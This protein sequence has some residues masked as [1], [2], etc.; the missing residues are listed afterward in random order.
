MKRRDFITISSL[1]SAGFTL[2]HCNNPVNS[3]NDTDTP[4]G[5]VSESAKNI[6]VKGKYDV[7]VC[8]GGPAG[9]AAAIKSGRAGV[10]TLLVETGGCLGGTWTAGLLPVILDYKNKTGLLQEI[11]TALENMNAR[12]IKHPT[13]A[14]NFD[15]ESMKLLLEKMCLDVGVDIL[16]HTRAVQVIKDKD[17]NISHVLTESKSFREAWES[18]IIVDATGDGD[19]GALAGCE[20]DMGKGEENSIQPMSFL[21]LISG[22]VHSE[23]GDYVRKMKNSWENNQRLKKL[24][25]AGGVETSYRNPMIFPIRENLFSIMANHEYGFH[26]TNAKD[27][28]EATINARQELHSIINALKS[29]GGIWKDIMIVATPSHIGVREGRRI[30]GLYTVTEE[31]LVNGARFDDAVVNVKFGVDVHNLKKD[32]DTPNSQHIK[33]KPYDIPLR[34][35][36]SK[37][38]NNL[39]M[40]GRCISGDFI[41]HASYRVTGNAVPLGEAAG[42][43]A[44]VAVQNNQVPK[45][46]SWEKYQ[47]KQKQ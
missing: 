36:I 41:A 24:I 42:Q 6:P 29:H 11:I 8:G 37:D 30:K 2:N 18:K 28:T 22:I 7:I 20:F 17:K 13:G 27:L 43:L 47:T 39:L 1:A 19:V 4:E 16:L 26:G 25:K 46:I 31:D 10:K 32:D 9:I 44:A 33:S 40:A 12:N 35:L 38:I 14:V 15:I 34:S 3:D 45:E 21:G 23:V 5:H